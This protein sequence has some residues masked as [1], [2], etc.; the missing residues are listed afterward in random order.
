MKEIESIYSYHNDLAKVLIGKISHRPCCG[1]DIPNLVFM[2]VDQ[3]QII[4]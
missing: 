1:E 2:S 4:F 3:R